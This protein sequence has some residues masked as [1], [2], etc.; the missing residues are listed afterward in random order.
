MFTPVGRSISVAVSS[1]AAEMNTSANAAA[2]PGAI[3]GSVTRSHAA[4]GRAPSERADLLE[5]R[6][7]LRHR[8]AHAD[9]RERQEQDRVGDDQLERALVEREGVVHRERDE[10]ERDHEPG[11]RHRQVGEA[12]EQHRRRGCGGASTS[13][14]TGTA[15]AVASAAAAAL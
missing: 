13:A 15:S 4:A 7:R 2:R 9:E 11:Q 1:V 14:R 8:R 12:L 6:G 5:P 3:S 10:A